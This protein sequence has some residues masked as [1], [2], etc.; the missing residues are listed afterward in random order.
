[1][2]DVAYL[3]RLNCAI[4]EAQRADVIDWEKLE[5]LYDRRDSLIDFWIRIS[6]RD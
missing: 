6:R 4:D 5:R 1:M 2:T 3:Y